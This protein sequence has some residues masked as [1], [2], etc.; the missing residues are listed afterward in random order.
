MVYVPA[1]PMG[2]ETEIVCILVHENEIGKRG[3]VQGNLYKTRQYLLS[4]D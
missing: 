2:A 1:P 3:Y 4:A